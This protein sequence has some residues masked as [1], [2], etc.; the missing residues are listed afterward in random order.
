M[1]PQ[2]GP[3]DDDDAVMFLFL[4]TGYINWHPGTLAQGGGLTGPS[5]RWT[6]SGGGRRRGGWVSDDDRL[7]RVSI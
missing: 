1:T 6:A 4:D 7:T 2:V 5:F 3:G